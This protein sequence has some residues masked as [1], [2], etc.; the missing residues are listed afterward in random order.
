VSLH[1]Q[2][3]LTVLVKEDYYLSAREKEVLS[4]LVKGYSHKMIADKLFITC[5]TVHARMVKI[6]EKLHNNSKTEVVAKAI[7]QRLFSGE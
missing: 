6:Y 5:A 2:S 4:L 1:F 3:D 7:N